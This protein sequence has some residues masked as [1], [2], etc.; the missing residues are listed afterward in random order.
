MSKELKNITENVMAKIHEGK[1][2]M[3]PKYYFVL[4]SVFS[5]LGLVFSIITSVF[6]VA[7]IRFSLRS[8]GRMADYK[9][10]YL[11]D[12]FPLWAPILAIVSIFIG[13]KLIRR[14]E[15]SY[16]NNFIGIVL[17][18]IL[19]IFVAGIVFDMTGLNELWLQK[20]PIRGI[21]K[22]YF[23]ESIY[24]TENNKIN[25]I[26]GGKNDRIRNNKLFL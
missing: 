24:R 2:K 1:I 4:G 17:L 13:I 26:K 11:I 9:L 10:D 20:G 8:G 19:A 5:F 21:M 3:K 22:N 16:K 6:L 23:T 12:I 15:F 18:F 14:Y 25:F 7:L